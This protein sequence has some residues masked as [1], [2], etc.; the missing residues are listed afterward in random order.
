MSVESLDNLYELKHG[1]N[2]YG[3][4]AIKSQAIEHARELL[5]KGPTGPSIVPCNNGNVQLE[6]HC[7]GMDVEIEIGENGIVDMDWNV[8][9]EE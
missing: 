4:R 2:S 5:E 3:G 8:A 1:W 7:N 6:W 9:C